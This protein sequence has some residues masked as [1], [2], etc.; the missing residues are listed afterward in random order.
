[1]KTLAAFTTGQFGQQPR[2][3]G[4]QTAS[5]RW[6][7]PTCCSGDSPGYWWGRFPSQHTSWGGIGIPK[8]V[9]RAVVCYLVALGLRQ[10]C[11]F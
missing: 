4:G 9:T 8:V 1:M 2:L 10:C 3:L 5:N 6:F 11:W 7:H